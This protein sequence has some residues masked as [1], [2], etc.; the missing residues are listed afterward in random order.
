MLWKVIFQIRR[1]KVIF[2]QKKLS[3]NS[4]I[5]LAVNTKKPQE[6][7]EVTKNT[8]TNKRKYTDSEDDI[9]NILK[10]FIVFFF[11]NFL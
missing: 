9:G 2:R 3:L 7:F 5:I 10:N 11:P 8:K 6:N 4:L 1:K